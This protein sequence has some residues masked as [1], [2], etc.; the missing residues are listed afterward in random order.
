MYE[1]KDI[2]I[3]DGNYKESRGGVSKEDDCIS[4]YKVVYV[5]GRFGF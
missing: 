2:Y 1:R 4:R 3:V 5:M